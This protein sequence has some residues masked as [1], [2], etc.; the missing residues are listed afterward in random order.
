MMCGMFVRR[1]RL[2]ISPSGRQQSQDDDDKNERGKQIGSGTGRF[3]GGLDFGANTAFVVGANL[4]RRPSTGWL[5]L[6]KHA[7]DFVREGRTIRG[8]AGVS[9]AGPQMTPMAT[10]GGATNS[11]PRL[12]GV[13]KAEPQIS[14]MGTDDGGQLERGISMCLLESPLERGARRAGCVTPL[15]FLLVASHP[16]PANPVNSVSAFFLVSWLPA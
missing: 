16:L 15:C 7:A 8:F 6:G 12:N 3:H 14:R 1:R 11:Y 9:E 10:N 13:A 5:F 4:L 2:A